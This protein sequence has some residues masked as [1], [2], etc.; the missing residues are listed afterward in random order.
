MPGR[1]DG[2]APVRTCVGCRERRTQDQLTRIARRGD[3]SL[4]PGR[5]LPGRGAWLCRASPTCL[6]LAIRRG[7]F[8]R[9]FRTSIDPAHVEEL[10]TTLVDPADRSDIDFVPGVPP[11][12]N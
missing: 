7:G 2:A 12:R 4:A 1:A 9:A 11:A 10:R 6:D 5:T 3:G 8:A